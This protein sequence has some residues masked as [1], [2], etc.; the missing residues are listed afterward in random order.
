MK[1]TRI[2]LKW[3]VVDIKAIVKLK[4][5]KLNLNLYLITILE[6]IGVF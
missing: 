4:I 5:G 3:T 2:D 1:K 6:D